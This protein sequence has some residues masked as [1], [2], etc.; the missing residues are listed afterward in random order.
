MAWNNR[1]VHIVD[2]EARCRYAVCEVFYEDDGTP[3]GYAELADLATESVEDLKG[4]VRLIYSDIIGR[5]Q[6]VLESEDL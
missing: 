6:P 2:D 4:L 1:I 3:R 5:D